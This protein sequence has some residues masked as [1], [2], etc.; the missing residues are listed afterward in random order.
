[1]INILPIDVLEE[2]MR[3]DL[4]RIRGSGSQSE[5]W[6]SREE[7]L[8]DGDAVSWHVDGVEGF[9]GEDGVVDFVFVF[10]A[11]WGLLEEHLVDE[12]TEGPPID[13]STVLF[14]KEDLKSSQSRCSLVVVTHNIPLVP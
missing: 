7:F 9:V 14:V 5:F 1:M 3:H 11:E 4:L 10:A 6:F 13:R 12:D 8:Q 2:R